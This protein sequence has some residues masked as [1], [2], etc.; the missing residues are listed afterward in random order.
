MGNRTSVLSFEASEA[1]LKL[2]YRCAVTDATGTY[3]SNVIKITLK[4]IV[5]ANGVIY[6]AV[7]D[8]TCKITG[9]TGTATALV[10]PETIEGMTVIEVGEEAFMGN[11]TLVSIDLPDT[12]QIIRARAFKN[13]SNLSTMS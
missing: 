6:S 4:N 8:T 13:C 11:Q 2:S 1:Y 7:S 3:Y 10:I 12:I 9:Y 5:D